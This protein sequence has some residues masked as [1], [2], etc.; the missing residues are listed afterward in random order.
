M[1]PLGD[2]EPCQLLS[3]HS[4]LVHVAGGVGGHLDDRGQRPD[5]NQPRQGT[6][7]VGV[8]RS[9]GRPP[10]RLASRAALLHGA[11]DHDVAGLSRRH[12]LRRRVE[13]EAHAFDLSLSPRG[14]DIQGVLDLVEVPVG[15]AGKVGLSAAGEH[16]QA[17][18]VVEAEA[19]IADRGH[20]RI[21]CQL[22]PRSGDLPTDGRLADPRD[23]RPPLEAF[24]AHQPT[25]ST[26]TK[27]GMAKP[28]G[29]GS[30]PTST[31]MSMATR[32]GSASR[33]RPT[34]RTPG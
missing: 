9:V 16:R 19:G 28:P 5:G 27:L 8:D 23:H 34:T 32:G 20:D 14:G 2:R 33:R 29:P 24:G 26:G 4:V 15:V 17:V 6:L 7:G 31:S 21:Q 25:P 12:G 11:P 18:D 13:R 22:E 3:S 1:H 30:N 10:A